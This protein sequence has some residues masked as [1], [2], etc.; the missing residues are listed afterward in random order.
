MILG[1]FTIYGWWPVHWIVNHTPVLEGVKNVHM[2]LLVDLSLAVLG[3]FGI[4]VLETEVLQISPSRKQVWI[5]IGIPFALAIAGI[6]TLAIS[7]HSAVPVLRRPAATAVFLTLGFILVA[8]RSANVVK[9]RPFLFLV[10]GLLSVDLVTFRSGILPLVPRSEIFPEA[11]AFNFLKAHADPYRFRVASISETYPPNA[12]MMYGLAGIGGDDVTLI[13]L[14]NVLKGFGPE[15]LDMV[16]LVGKTVAASNDRRLDLLNVKYLVA[17]TFNESYDD[18]AGRPDRFKLVYSDGAVWIFENLNVLPRTFFVPAANNSIEVVPDEPQELL[19]LRDP[20][21]DPQKSVI[22]NA[23]PPGLEES[24]RR[25]GLAPLDTQNNVSILSAHINGLDLAVENSQPGVLI[26][27]QVF[28]PGWVAT[29]D[30][31]ETPV[32]PADYAVVGVP[33]NAGTHAIKLEFRPLSFRIGLI[34]SALSIL[35]VAGL[36]VVRRKLSTPNSALVR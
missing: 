21:F 2:I 5:A 16:S 9:A 14:K 7:T 12:E 25:S 19:R 20:S 36:L 22:L 32:V 6:R 15:S 11:P 17:T 4:T 1:I 29:V 24:K 28:Y 10:L 33:L 34:I 31:K 30:G 13:R 26:V 23:L 35:L 18:L 27:S 3:G 8:L